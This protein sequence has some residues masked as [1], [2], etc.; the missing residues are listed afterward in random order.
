MDRQAEIDHTANRGRRRAAA[1]KAPSKTNGAGAPLLGRDAILA[2]DD[3]ATERVP[4]PEW[5]GDVLIRAVSL[6]ER[7]AFEQ[8]AEAADDDNGA[9]L[10]RMVAL[11]AVDGDGKPLFMPGDVA[12]LAA[13]GAAPILRLSRV[14]MRLNGLIASDIEDLA[15]N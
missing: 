13:K 8:A 9:V 10:A 4:V 14:A 11:T 3:L 2:A 12:A 5:G 7:E 1:K 15:K 6:A